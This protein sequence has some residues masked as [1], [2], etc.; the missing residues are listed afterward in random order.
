MRT[1]GVTTHLSE[2]EILTWE[3][4]LASYARE[5]LAG[6]DVAHDLA[7]LRR[8]AA[9]AR[10]LASE[11]GARHEVVMP[12]VWL[13]D[14]VHVPKDSPDRARASRLAAAE[15]ARVL[16][17]W[18]YPPELLPEIRHAIE[19]HSYSAAIAPTTLEAKVVQDADRLDALGAVGIARC[20]M[21]GGSMGKALAAPSDPFCDERAPDD[22]LYVI[23]H[24]YAKLLGLAETMQTEGGRREALSRTAV[25]RAYLD[26]LRAELGG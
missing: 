7:H 15:A 21:L 26:Q 5:A 11:E 2:R 16:S 24:F 3:K 18:G 17:G 20:L 19:A 23:D 9:T 25:M 10:R 22:S 1:H 4:K 12:A 14:C 8:V 13:H 6:G